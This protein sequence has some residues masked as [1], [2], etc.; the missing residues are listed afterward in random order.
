[1]EDSGTLKKENLV[2]R[3]LSEVQKCNGSCRLQDFFSE[4]MGFYSKSIFDLETG[5]PEEVVVCYAN[6]Y[7]L[8]CAEKF[9]TGLESG[10][11]KYLLEIN[12]RVEVVSKKPKSPYFDLSS[13]LSEI[14][15]ADKVLVQGG[16]LIDRSPDSSVNLLRRHVDI[17][18]KER[19]IN[20]VSRFF[21]YAT[22]P[23][24]RLAFKVA[25]VVNLELEKDYP[26]K[27]EVIVKHGLPTQFSD[28]YI[29]DIDFII[30]DAMAKMKLSSSS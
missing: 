11:N 5:P 8:N 1:M 27:P 13:V 20:P 25:K 28:S 15:F 26:V 2:C 19:V 23:H 4:K 16:T 10:I 9:A 14:L 3:V 7:F 29:I 24:Q 6:P 22:R 12:P 30:H 21:V 18:R 17:R